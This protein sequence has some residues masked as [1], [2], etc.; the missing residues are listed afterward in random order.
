MLVILCPFKVLKLNFLD[1]LYVG[2][3]LVRNHKH[4]NIICEWIL[5]LRTCKLVH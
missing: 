1:L 4:L 2:W 3:Q 5:V